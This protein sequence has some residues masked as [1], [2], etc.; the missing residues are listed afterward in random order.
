[1]AVKDFLFAVFMNDTEYLRE[2]LN[3]KNIALGEILS[4]IEEEKKKIKKD[5]MDN[6]EELVFPVLAKLKRKGSALDKKYIKLLEDSLT[7]ITSTFGGIISDRK[8][9]LSPREIE[10]CHMVQKGLTT[11]DI[12]I[13]LSTSRRTIDNHRNRIR[14]KLGV[15][16]HKINLASCLRMIT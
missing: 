6:V 15:S 13:L 10:I 4:R 2:E 11:K 7:Q 9:K 16:H 3:H 12:S 14:K 1:M 8:W 5:I